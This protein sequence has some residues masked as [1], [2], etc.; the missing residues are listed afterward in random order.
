MTAKN[1]QLDHTYFKYFLL[2]VILNFLSISS[3][4]AEAEYSQTSA[5]FSNKELYPTGLEFNTDG[6]KMYITGTQGSN[7]TQYSLT[8]PFDVSTIAFEVNRQCWLL[9]E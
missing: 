1:S 8:T 7:V 2:L 9:C 6:D 5:S 3:A 4:Y